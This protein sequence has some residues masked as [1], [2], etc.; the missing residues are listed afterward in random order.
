MEESQSH[1]HRCTQPAGL[2]VGGED[3]DETGGHTHQRHCGNQGL[4]S[5]DAVTNVS[6]KNGPDWSDD[7]GQGDR[8]EGRQC[9]TEAS[10]RVKK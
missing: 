5:A 2:V 3:S 4:P 1:K 9:S 6:E 10:Q 7:E 8:E